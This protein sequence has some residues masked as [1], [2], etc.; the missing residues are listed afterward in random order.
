MVV[1]GSDGDDDDDDE[2]PAPAIAPSPP[3]PKA[4][5]RDPARHGASCE[6]FGGLTD[7]SIV[8]RAANVEAGPLTFVSLAEYARVPAAD[9]EARDDSLY[10]AQKVLLVMRGGRDATVVVP[11]SE[12]SH[13]SL[14][15]GPTPGVDRKQER[16]GLREI[17]DGNP[18]VRFKGCAGKFM[19]YVGG[20]FVVAGARC[21]PL[22]IWVEG[23]AEPRR[24]VASFG[25]REGCR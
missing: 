17:A 10:L 20:G 7:P 13:A 11:K 14:L 3:T 23:D 22:D 19:E 2:S 1:L 4:Q 24:I 6:R 9:F 25:V 18:A 8:R 5:P 15:W 21:L 12:R 16:L